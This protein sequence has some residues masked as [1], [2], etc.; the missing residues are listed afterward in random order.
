MI[1]ALVIPVFSIVFVALIVSVYDEKASSTF[2]S[3]WQV[4]LLKF[5]IKKTKLDQKKRT[6]SKALKFE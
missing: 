1:P 5:D 6:A 4:N 3:Q 2:R